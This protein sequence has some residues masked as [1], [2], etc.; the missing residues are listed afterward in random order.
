MEK[1]N[2]R[3]NEKNQRL[4]RSNRFA[5]YGERVRVSDDKQD[6]FVRFRTTRTT[7]LVRNTVNSSIPAYQVSNKMVCSKLFVWC[8]YSILFIE[9]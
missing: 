7:V 4:K 5:S 2:L 1:K 9:V 6:A 8:I 3:G